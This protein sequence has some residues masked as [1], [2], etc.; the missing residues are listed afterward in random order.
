MEG[1]SQAGCQKAKLKNL[2]RHETGILSID[3]V[4]ASLDKYVAS[5]LKRHSKKAIIGAYCYED[6]ALHTF[7]EARRNH[8]ACLYDLPIGYWRA[9]KRYS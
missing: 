8:M 7:R 2:I 9:S 6:G 1:S 4:Y 5:N 3:A